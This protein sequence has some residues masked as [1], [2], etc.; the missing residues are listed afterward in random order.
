MSAVD[1][2]VLNFQ[3]HEGNYCQKAQDRPA[4]LLQSTATGSRLTFVFGFPSGSISP[5]RSA[6]ADLHFEDVVIDKDLNK[7]TMS[8]DAG[9]EVT[10]TPTGCYNSNIQKQSMSGESG[11]A[12][13]STSTSEYKNAQKYKVKNDKKYSP[14]SE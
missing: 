6:S 9:V 4:F 1:R 13:E 5:F 14:G 11:V 2:P 12:A 3:F 7:L 8:G 10:T